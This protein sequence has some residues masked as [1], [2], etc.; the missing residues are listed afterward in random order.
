LTSAIGARMLY[1]RINE[2]PAHGT[3]S[4][5]GDFNCRSLGPKMA[6]RI[7]VIDDDPLVR[8]TIQD[9]LE[10]QG[11]EVVPAIHGEDGLHKFQA[12]PFDLVIVDI[13]MP[14]KEGLE[15]VR[16]LRQL[17]AHT[18]IVAITGALSAQ[19]AAR[20]SDPSLDYLRM[21]RSLG[22]TQTLRKPFTAHQLLA[23]VKQSLAA[24]EVRC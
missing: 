8:L 22:A 23:L 10:S 20:L 4:G 7:L 15:T 24:S 13:L 3:T 16:E 6:P 18:A 21:A 14:E 12:E 1:A 11:Y 9:S 2:S 5:D 17:S 19:S